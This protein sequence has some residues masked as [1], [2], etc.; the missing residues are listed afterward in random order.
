MGLVEGGKGIPSQQRRPP[1]WVLGLWPCSRRLV[2]LWGLL[3]W[4]LLVGGLGDGGGVPGGALDIV[5]DIFVKTVEDWEVGNGFGGEAL[6]LLEM[7][8]TRV[9]AASDRL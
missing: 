4:A 5:A 9:V 1:Q 2:G 7:G 8:Q 6:E 3:A